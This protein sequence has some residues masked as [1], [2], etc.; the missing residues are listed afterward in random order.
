M[1]K[2]T[3]RA[4]KM[5]HYRRENR[6]LRSELKLERDGRTEDNKKYNTDREAMKSNHEAAIKSAEA[7]HER[8][9]EKEAA[10]VSN[11][12]S[13]IEQSQ[14]E[15]DGIISK[16]KELHGK[17][18]RGNSEIIIRLQEAIQVIERH[19]QESMQNEYEKLTNERA[20]FVKRNPGLP[21]QITSEVRN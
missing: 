3:K 19:S 8:A 5:S 9:M 11:A 15:L 2:P 1:K 4:R 13:R 10:K 6:R 16:F 14:A 17:Q 18:A 12:L 20:K 21:Y 7:R